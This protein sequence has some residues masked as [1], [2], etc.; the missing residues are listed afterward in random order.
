MTDLK[1]TNGYTVR[2]QAGEQGWEVHILDASSEVTWTR[3]CIDEAEARTFASSVHQH[4][5]WLS[6]EKFADYYKLAEPAG[7]GL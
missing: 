2:V 4:I 5:Y 6:A 1:P 3:H 7:P